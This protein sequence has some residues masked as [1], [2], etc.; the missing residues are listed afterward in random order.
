MNV[1]QNPMRRSV[2]GSWVAKMVAV[3]AQGLRLFIVAAAP[4]V[5]SVVTEDY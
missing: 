1:P 3:G 4:A 5:L 2:P